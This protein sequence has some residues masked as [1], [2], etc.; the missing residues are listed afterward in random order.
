M[1]KKIRFI[2]QIASFAALVVIASSVYAKS[3]R[4]MLKLPDTG[5]TISYTDTFGEDSDYSINTPTYTDNGDTVTDEVT[6]L[7]WQKN[8]VLTTTTNNAANVYCD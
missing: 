4:Q 7:I 2:V 6:G 1:F 3:T 8:E 5:Q